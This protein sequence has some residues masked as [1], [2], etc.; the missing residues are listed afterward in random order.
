MKENI[1]KKVEYYLYNYKNIDNI[2]LDIRQNIIDRVDI[3]AN[4][5]LR[6]KS[7]TGNTVE[8]QAIKLAENKKIYNLKKIQKV[9]QHYL[10]VFRNKNPKRYN[11]I[12]MKYFDKATPLEIEKKLKYSAKQQKDI[13]DMVVSFFYRQFKKAQIGGM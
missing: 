12:K 11:F 4:G 7:S 6:G 3:S 9:I 2:I 10:E 13:T 5:W 8:N 1:Y